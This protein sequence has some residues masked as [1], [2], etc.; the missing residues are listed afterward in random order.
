MGAQKLSYCVENDFDFRIIK[1]TIWD[2][3][4]FICDDLNSFNWESEMSLSASGLTV[5]IFSSCCYGQIQ[6]L[7][8]SFP[9]GWASQVSC[10]IIRNALFCLDFT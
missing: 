10:R 4:G 8:F 2:L 7:I 3:T 6:Y 5:I 1:L 9:R